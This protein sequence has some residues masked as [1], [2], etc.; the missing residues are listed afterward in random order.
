MK[1]LSARQATEC[2]NVKT[3][4]CRCRCGGE[5]NGAGRVSDLGYLPERD[6]H[7][8]PGLRTQLSLALDTWIGQ[9]GAG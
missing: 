4:R 1:S 5:F 2:E 7:H 3:S 8:V 6:P 9:E